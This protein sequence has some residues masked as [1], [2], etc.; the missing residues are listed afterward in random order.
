MRLLITYFGVACLTLLLTNRAVRR[1]QASAAIFV[2]VVPVLFLGE[3]FATG[4][5]Y[6]PLDIVYGREPL[7]TY[8][9]QY[10]VGTQRT[11]ILVDVVDMDIPWLKAVREAV[12]N[13]RL[14]LWN[15]FLLAGE[16]LL[17]VQQ[18]AALY[19]GTWLGFA[20]PLAQAWTFSMALRIFL[21]LLSAVLLLRDLQCSNVAACFGGASW[22]LCDFLIFTLGYPLGAA[23]G[24]LPLLILGLRR[25]AVTGGTEGRGI[26]IAAMA[27]IISAGHPETSLHAVVFAGVFFLVVVFQQPAGRRARPIRQGLLAGVLGVGLMAVTLAPF[28]EILPHTFE[29]RLRAG[30]YAASRKSVPLRQSLVS[31]EAQVV[32]YSMGVSGRS[33]MPAFY[34]ASGY[35]GSLVLLFAAVGLAVRGSHR[36]PTIVT[37]LL[38]LGVGI[39]LRGVADLIGR[40]P[41]LNIAINQR[42]VFVGAFG[43]AVFA[44]V[45]VDAALRRGWQ[46]MATAGLV[47]AALIVAI[48]FERRAAM[49]MLGMAPRYMEQRLALQILPLVGLM[50]VVLLRPRG[51]GGGPTRFAWVLPVALVALR[52]PEIGRFYPVVPNKAFYPPLDALKPIDRHEP[53]RFAAFGVTFVPNMAALYELEDARGYEAMT[54]SRLVETFPLWC[55]PQGF[56]FNRIDDP[57]KPFLSFLNV[58]Y[59]LAPVGYGTPPG[60]H[61]AGSS[62][63]GILLE[64]E[65]VLPRAFIPRRV[66]C[67]AS[68]A[69]ELAALG[70]IRN[71]GDAGVASLG[72]TTNHWSEN[73][74][75]S[76]RI[77]AY[78]SDRLDVGVVATQPTLLATSITAWPGW[79]VSVD[80]RP[81]RP[82]FY[83]HA[84]LG[85]QL[86]AGTHDV[87]FRYHPTGFSVGAAVT[88]LTIVSIGISLYLWRRERPALRRHHA[89]LASA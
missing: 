15:R 62:T 29:Y 17:A 64:N 59:F 26:T 14:P 53:S 85:V 27:L 55:V 5:V 51:G 61:E 54:L 86:Q 23:A 41:L 32:P 66:L 44:A 45:G 11:P 87:A 12:K 58:R 46:S 10:G 6:A 50:V 48:W 77:S 22:A 83:N 76:A 89:D 31:L 42:L 25:I 24:L 2:V 82:V 67:A 70:A 30:Y 52:Y 75:A 56:W 74:L 65:R 60:W 35:G 81:T 72:C 13:G 9:A 18:S 57:T 79:K 3:A 33:A 36:L 47:V 73:G 71:F 8:R 68:A 1:L 19:P 39:G 69:E 38:A 20:L 49:L 21:A 80:G 4:G 40:L 43:V 78:R 63:G 84:F 7:A 37:S 34:E 28:A 16:P 88:C